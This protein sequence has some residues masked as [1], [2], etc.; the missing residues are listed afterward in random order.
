MTKSLKTKTTAGAGLLS[1]L[2]GALMVFAPAASGA[3]DPAVEPYVGDIACTDSG[4]GFDYGVVA[5]PVDTSGAAT[6]I[7][8]GEIT[9]T[10]STR[11]A[12]LDGTQTLFVDWTSEAVDADAEGPILTVLVLQGNGGGVFTYAAPGASSGTV[13]VV[14]AVGAEPTG[15]E[16]LSFCHDGAVIAPSSPTDDADSPTS[17]PDYVENTTSTTEDVENTTSTTEG[18]ETT[19]S[20]TEATTTTSEGVLGTTSTVP[21][22]TTTSAEGEL[23]ATSTTE[24]PE[25]LNNAVA[26]NS[27]PATGSGSDRV[28]AIG[29]SLMILGAILVGGSR[30]SL[31]G[32]N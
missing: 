12:D 14:P 5:A 17:T 20:T 31:V 22:T 18:V 6:T 10:Y 7:G 19:T 4:T 30:R 32:Q 24:G 8:D 21:E 3:D 11:L 9:V 26:G 25:V 1:F 2:L 16:K 15:V 13:H 28:A 23:A 27:L 29:A